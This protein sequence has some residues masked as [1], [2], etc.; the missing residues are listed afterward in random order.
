MEKLACF[1][2]L[3]AVFSVLLLAVTSAAAP[4]AGVAADVTPP[5]RP[6]LPRS[7][8]SSPPSSLPSLSPSDAAT[9]SSIPA[10][11]QPSADCA[12][13]LF[14]FPARSS[15]SFP[16][17]A[18]SNWAPA[19]SSPSRAS[20]AP[21]RA[22]LASWGVCWPSLFSPFSSLFPSLPSPSSLLSGLP[23]LLL[24]SAASPLESPQRKRRSRS[25]DRGDEREEEETKKKRRGKPREEAPEHSE[26]EV[27]T[28]LPAGAQATRT[29]PEELPASAAPTVGASPPSHTSV[30]SS[31]S[32]AS[33]SSSSAS[34]PSPLPSPSPSPSPSSLAATACHFSCLSC[35][36]PGSRE[37][38]LSCPHQVSSPSDAI[39]FFSPPSAPCAPAPL[40]P[41]L[42][43]P[44]AESPVSPLSEAFLSRVSSA[45][46]RPSALLL[47]RLPHVLTPM[48]R[49]GSGL[50]V[51]VAVGASEL[52]ADTQSHEGDA[53][54]CDLSS[55][56]PS[57]SSSSCAF[58]SASAGSAA[59]SSFSGLS[60]APESPP[61]KEEV[62]E[63]ARE[64]ERAWAQLQGHCHPS[65]VTCRAD[66]CF[67]KADNCLSCDVASSSLRRLYPDG[68]G[69]CL[70]IRRQRRDDAASLP[71]ASFPLA[72]AGRGATDAEQ[73]DAWSA[74]QDWL[75][76]LTGLLDVESSWELIADHR[77]PPPSSPASPS[78]SSVSPPSSPASPSP[79]PASPP[80]SPASPSPS[81]A[82]PSPSPASPSSASLPASS[83][84]VPTSPPSA[85]T[86]PSSAPASS[87]SS[88]FPSSPPS[89]S[90]PEPSSSTSSTARPPPASTAGALP[91][92][93]A[94][95]AVPPLLSAFSSSPFALPSASSSLC[96]SLPASA[97]ALPALHFLHLFFLHADNNLEESALLD[98]EE[99]LNPYIGRRALHAILAAHHSGVSGS[100]SPGGAASEA[101]RQLA[102]HL[103][104][105][106][107]YVVALL[108]R[109]KAGS[110]SK[111]S[112]ASLG[113][114][115]VC[116]NLSYTQKGPIRT[117][118]S[119]TFFVDEAWQ[120]TVELSSE[121]AYELLRVKTQDGR[122]E[123]MLLRDH[124][125]VDMNSPAVLASF[126]QRNLD[127]FPSK[128]AAL[129]LW[130]HGSAWVG[131][132][133]DESSADHAPMSLQDI[134]QG[135]QKGLRGSERGK[136]DLA[137][138]FSVL[139]FD[140]CLMASYD[141]LEA[142][143][144][145]AHF[146]IASEDNE[147]GH[148]WNY[149]LTDPTTLFL[150][151]E[152][153]S[154]S[155]PASA[156]PSPRRP[157][158]S[159]ASASRGEASLS[160]VAF[161]AS[162]FRLSTAYE[163]ASRFIASYALHPRSSVALTLSLIEVKA[164][165]AFKH[166]FEEV[167]DHLFACGGSSISSLV[168]R[169]LAGSFTVRGCEMVSL[170]SCFDLFDFLDNLL[171][172]LAA[173][174]RPPAA[175][176]A[177]SAAA[178]TGGR[179]RTGA[180]LLALAEKVARLRRLLKAMVVME[181]GG[182]EEG[183]Y[184][185]L[186]MYFPDPNMQLNC[187]N[188]RGASLWADHYQR[189]IRSRYA[190]F[191]K[192]VRGNRLG[193]VCY[194]SPS[195]SAASPVAGAP[196][197]AAEE[198]REDG[199]AA[200]ALR[201]GYESQPFVVLEARLLQGRRQAGRDL[202][203]LAA[204]A[205]SSLIFALMFRGFVSELRAS[206]PQER[207]SPNLDEMPDVYPAP[208]DAPSSNSSSVSPAPS[209]A[210]SPASSSSAAAAALGASG[211]AEAGGARGARDL[212][213]VVKVFSTLQ[214]SITD[215]SDVDWSL[216]LVDEEAGDREES[217]PP[218]ER[219]RETNAVSAAAAGG[220]P[221]RGDAKGTWGFASPVAGSAASA[222]FLVRPSAAEGAEAAARVEG[223]GERRHDRSSDGAVRVSEGY[224]FS[225][226]GDARVPHLS[227]EKRRKGG[228]TSKG[229]AEKARGGRAKQRPVSISV[230]ESWWD[231][232]VWVL[233][234]RQ[235]V[236]PAFK[237][238]RRRL[239]AETGRNG[240][241]AVRES[242]TG[243]EGESGADD[244]DREER[245][246][247]ARRAPPPPPP[248]VSPLL[249][250]GATPQERG[251]ERRQ[252][253][254]ET[255]APMRDSSA[256]KEQDTAAAREAGGETGNELADQLLTRGPWRWTWQPRDSGAE[257]QGAAPGRQEAGSREAA[258]G[259]G[260]NPEGV[261]EE[262]SGDLALG[263]HQPGEEGDFLE[264]L[265]VA[266]QDVPESPT[267][268]TTEARRIFTFPFIFYQDAKA[269][270]CAH[271]RTQLSATRRPKARN[272]EAAKGASVSVAPSLSPLPSSDPLVSSSDA[273][274]TLSASSS[275][276]SFSFLSSSLSAQRPSVAAARRLD[277]PE[278]D[279]AETARD[280]E[281]P[282]AAVGEARHAEEHAEERISVGRQPPPHPHLPLPPAFSSGPRSPPT[283]RTARKRQS[284]ASFF[285][286]PVVI[287]SETLVS[288]PESGALRQ[289]QSRPR[290]AQAPASPV[291]SPLA[292]AGSAPPPE[293]SAGV[294]GDEDGKPCGE[295]AYL[296]GEIEGDKV[297]KIALYVVA[298]NMSA[299]RPRS[300]GGIL[301]PIQK[302]FT[303]ER[304]HS[305]S[306]GASSSS[307]ASSS[308]PRGRR[309][310]AEAGAEEVQSRESWFQAH[311]AEAIREDRDAQSFLS[312]P[313]GGA[314][315]RAE[316]E[317][318]TLGAANRAETSSAD[319]RTREQPDDGGSGES[320]GRERDERVAQWD[321]ITMEEM[322]VEAL[323]L[324]GEAEDVGEL[325]VVSI[326]RS[327]Y[328]RTRLARSAAAT[329]SEKPRRAGARDSSSSEREREEASD[330][331]QSGRTTEDGVREA[332]AETRHILGFVMQSVA[333][334]R[335]G[336]LLSLP[337]AEARDDETSPVSFF[338]SLFPFGGEA[339]AKE[340]QKEAACPPEWI[341]D[342]ICD[343][344]CDK[345]EFFSDGG[346]CPHRS[347]L[348][349]LWID[350]Q[351]AASPPV[352]STVWITAAGSYRCRCRTGY[353]GDGLNCRDIDECADEKN[354]PCHPL[355]L[356]V[357]TNGGFRCIC[358]AEHLGDG[359]T[360]CV[361]Q[362][363]LTGQEAIGGSPES[364]SACAGKDGRSLC[365]GT[366]H[367]RP[368]GSCGCNEGYV[369]TADD[370][371]EDIDECDEGLAACAPASLAV[372]I[373][374][375]GGYFCSC[376]EGYEG[377]GRQ[378]VKGPSVL[379]ARLV[380]SVD[381]RR[382]M[383]K[384]GNEDGFALLFR[385]SLSQ[386]IPSLSLDRVEVVEVKEGSVVLLLRVHPASSTR[387]ASPRR[388]A[389]E[390]RAAG[391]A[392][393]EGRK[394]GEADAVERKDAETPQE[395]GG[396]AR[397]E[398]PL[399]A[400]EVLLALQSQLEEPTSP[401]RTGPFAEYAAVSSLDEYRFLT[402]AQAYGAVDLLD[403]LTSWLP[404]WITENIPRAVIVAVELGLALVLLLVL[405]NCCVKCCRRRTKQ[406]SG[407]ARTVSKRRL[408]PVCCCCAGD[409]STSEDEQELAYPP[410]RPSLAQRPPSRSHEASM[411]ALSRAA[412]ASRFDDRA[413][414]AWRQFGDTETEI[415]QDPGDLYA[416][417][418]RIGEREDRKRRQGR[419]GRRA[420]SRGEGVD[421]RRPTDAETL[422]RI[423]HLEA[424]HRH[425]IAEEQRQKRLARST[426]T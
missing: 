144:P 209:P 414:A 180:P 308:S 110:P 346:D 318:L 362:A 276:S 136:K 380:V 424:Y 280:G 207:L 31:P 109:P 272:E 76:S 155:R 182:R 378:C 46:S 215:L 44:P 121:S 26:D 33:A 293:A 176:F 409:L 152:G 165:L 190:S 329:Q 175:G 13:C 22:S 145:F 143:A 294:F 82:S 389:A 120:G 178:P 255:A 63:K 245:R 16:F 399:T 189:A 11:Q 352:T 191:V 192:S 335:G 299:E 66:C 292:P 167:M 277:T 341:G 73:G 359:I 407:S 117:R 328:A 8:L 415:V 337:H 65:C 77:S 314:R 288:L 225:A 40:S 48:F 94:S 291:P 361:P 19:M 35:A 104:L 260:D 373:N 161:A 298:G 303:F 249:T 170:C 323:F 387:H 345:P 221:A 185:G 208:R 50:C 211:A 395:E 330:A 118:G 34:T 265:L 36:R 74:S 224:R 108:D 331:Q 205:P 138:K 316:G 243:E 333:E 311:L 413:E 42:L 158:F 9:S 368:D 322:A 214:A 425:V 306:S 162:P 385:R 324:W 327:S 239:A 403:I 168:R 234:Q 127:L 383:E 195:L 282:A 406:Q 53:S 252:I 6:D 111:A 135:L 30:L 105:A 356:C 49:D 2:R 244:P 51:P 80:S 365:P 89:S 166:K 216:P 112:D 360:F 232:R 354:A 27:Q 250:A 287:S 54:S 45:S 96:G 154:T 426:Y 339:R 296:L 58:A 241:E 93:A 411:H 68:T 83:S 61:R 275:F 358:K 57:T 173:Q 81:P 382:T 297:S 374:T 266:M 412:S 194:F 86:S 131:F 285:S 18:D 84:S 148:G 347:S 71:L 174:H 342:S 242:E 391:A 348:G 396:S 262:D 134:A 137:F 401:L 157:F 12:V 52:G 312:L 256:K 289:L 410:R 388:P 230:A 357:N 379:H 69:R 336:F 423:R 390:V 274:T 350:Q 408:A 325:E 257:G 248:P 106:Q 213:V 198:A 20:S 150:D 220:R 366:L 355:A 269:L 317:G 4:F 400:A 416:A 101:H 24:G 371:C 151:A 114:V 102:A 261:A 332:S 240:R 38:C 290:G 422:E 402:K 199:A 91:S 370:S 39:A 418:G 88:A 251:G 159:S 201:Q 320:E 267:R 147:P 326:S 381:F 204:V 420:R 7:L 47:R 78:P 349:R 103:A 210:P 193:S 113:R 270:E 119:K 340:P 70:R 367:C 319:R 393:A 187:K 183:R 398:A 177:S 126:I 181:V 23:V 92:A 169:A 130:N 231:E 238:P 99:L 219:G 223:S 188:T 300:S 247:Y 405:F 64:R 386:A 115:H 218:E 197:Q 21:V 372:C 56:S 98:L 392:Q 163:Y 304:R 305:S 37:A 3:L 141:V 271:R 179:R 343:P 417:R 237:D 295:R 1:R 153:D 278:R 376:R 41:P 186:S 156:P 15:R 10:S 384:E 72:A 236:L 107:I 90:Y 375:E 397:D 321:G 344:P 286:R 364:F 62:A 133:D 404:A 43:S 227:A 353:E 28:A 17:F 253:A 310:G 100:G 222:P 363:E 203:G 140:A 123:W 14:P 171:R 254:G 122:F 263:E 75:A 228:E 25:G 246:K 55:L 302:L 334:E 309:L 307:S 226:A 32:S 264:S 129:T 229:T 259:V 202:V 60:P 281:T 124:G 196:P 184:S 235:G 139:G 233:R 394:R 421:A 116:G 217:L 172:L 146:V 206:T 142:V 268:R 419:G 200:D 128:H 67:Q 97:A 315:A 351:Q 85:P 87:P 279:R 212:R 283:G 59:S 79:S 369:Q 313:R 301:Q 377:D 338:S 164:F 29:R 160:A 95:A 284:A 258:A 273:V 125:D 132:G 5:T 149:H